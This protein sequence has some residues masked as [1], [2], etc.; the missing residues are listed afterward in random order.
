MVVDVSFMA[1]VVGHIAIDLERI[2]LFIREQE[3]L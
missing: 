3:D 2:T 1:C